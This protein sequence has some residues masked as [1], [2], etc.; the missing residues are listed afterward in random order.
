MIICGASVTL[1]EVWFRKR[2]ALPVYQA[3]DQELFHKFLEKKKLPNVVSINRNKNEVIDEILMKSKEILN[4]K[5]DKH[6]KINEPK[7]DNL[8]LELIKQVNV[9]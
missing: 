4:S 9:C 3:K 8:L 2:L 7:I 6:M 5:K 1:H